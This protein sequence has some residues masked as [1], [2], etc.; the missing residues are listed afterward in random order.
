MKA[1]WDIETADRCKLPELIQGICERCRDCRYCRRP[2][3][4]FDT[5]GKDGERD[6]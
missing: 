2:I 1:S 4:L 3:T 5:F 6:E